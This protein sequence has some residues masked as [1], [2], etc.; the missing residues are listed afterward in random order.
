MRARI[1]A[2]A[3]AVSVRLWRLTALA[4]RCP[5]DLANAITTAAADVAGLS[6]A[7]MSE[8][9]NGAH[10]AAGEAR[11]LYTV[12]ALQDRAWSLLDEI[13]DMAVRASVGSS[14]LPD[15]PWPLH[16]VAAPP[17]RSPPQPR[18]QTVVA[19]RL[20]APAQSSSTGSQKARRAER[21]AAPSRPTDVLARAVRHGQRRLREVGQRATQVV[22]PV[23]AVAVAIA[24]GWL[25]MRAPLFDVP[26]AAVAAVTI[27]EPDPRAAVSLV[28][29]AVAEERPVFGAV[30]FEAPDAKTVTAYLNTLAST[31]SDAL[32]GLTPKVLPAAGRTNAFRLVAWPPRT[33]EQALAICERLRGQ[34][35]SA[36][37]VR[38]L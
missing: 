7:G 20:P 14:R 15:A 10:T 36:C 33:K 17:L 5:P 2:R 37:T 25:V 30:L 19:P 11:A 28:T 4:R 24:I 18:M 9:V 32:A 38:R 1:I 13:E 23:G 16:P 29:G 26:N 3:E 12:D 31:Q 27:A 6:S 22:L 21:R 34:G 35:V 8:L